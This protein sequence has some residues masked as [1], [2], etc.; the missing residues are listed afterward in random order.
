MPNNT[1]DYWDKASYKCKFKRTKQSSADWTIERFMIN[2]R[3]YSLSAT[4]KKIV[5][6][7]PLQ[8]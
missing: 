3:S 1:D 5:T 6:Q 7:I 8:L 2:Y 4:L